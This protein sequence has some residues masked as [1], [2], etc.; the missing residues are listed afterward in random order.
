MKFGQIKPFENI[1][2]ESKKGTPPVKEM[3]GSEDREAHP[4]DDRK[5]EKR[6]DGDNEV[7]GKEKNKGENIDISV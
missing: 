7:K 1:Y 4:E 6:K 5:L 3:E 2:P